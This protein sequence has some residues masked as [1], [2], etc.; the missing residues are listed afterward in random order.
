MND[1]GG[2]RAALRRAAW[3][4][5]ASL[6]SLLVLGAVAVAAGFASRS[7]SLTAFGVAA[8]IE[9]LSA[10][11]VLWRLWAET[12]AGSVE[13]AAELVEGAERGAARFIAVSFA[14]LALLIAAGAVR[15]VVGRAVPSPGLGA[16]A[17]ACAAALALPGLAALKSRA[18]RLI[19]N[20]A[21]DADAA[22]TLACGGM[23]WVLLAGLLAQRAGV[24]WADPA[25]A[26]LI[27][28]LVV[29][30]AWGTWQRVSAAPRE[31]V[32][33]FLG[34]GSNV[35]DR[36]YWLADA[37]SKL[38]GPALSIVR[39]SRIYETPPWGKTDQPAFLNQ[40]LEVETMLAPSA[41]LARCQAVERAL[42]R[43]REER[44][45]PRV[46]DVDILLYGDAA[47]RMRGLTVPHAELSR[48]A[49]VLVPLLE[50]RPSLVLPDGRR[51]A[52]LLGALP[53]RDAI[54]PWT[55]DARDGAARV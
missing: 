15:A 5:I 54:V 25:A 13:G 27:G 35:G 48:R 55:A 40:V 33:A 34:L 1:A 49:F 37:A 8:L 41:L 2:L 50:L 44:W 14:A 30:E 26:L 36:A 38:E 51:A 17:L 24:W 46:I 29:R 4:E 10:S 31:P 18:A 23:A 9:I 39:R 21:L 20:T 53:E 11:A 19:G 22:A 3:L 28:G 12:L 16:L 32:R 42:G 7:V 6:F 45:G 47:L 43:V 52:E